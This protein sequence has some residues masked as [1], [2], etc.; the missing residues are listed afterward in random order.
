MSNLRI[1]NKKQTSE[2][3]NKY[4]IKMMS[5]YILAKIFEKLNNKQNKKKNQ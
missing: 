5:I 3:Y 2:V 1:T 4:N